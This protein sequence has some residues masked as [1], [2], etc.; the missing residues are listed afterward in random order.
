[1]KS[2]NQNLAESLPVAS[3]GGVKDKT[4][5]AA[6]KAKPCLDKAAAKR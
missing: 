2:E 6:P 3:A 4:D 1:M 5:V